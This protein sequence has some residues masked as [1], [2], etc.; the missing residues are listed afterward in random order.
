[1]AQAGSNDKKNWG[2]KISLDCPFK[3]FV[4]SELF[5]FNIIYEKIR[6]EKVYFYKSQVFKCLVNIG[7]LFVFWF[8]NKDD[9]NC[10]GE[11]M[12]GL[13]TLSIPSQRLPYLQRYSTHS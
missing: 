8:V 2:S 3:H 11:V 5:E 10:V 7:I 13:V 4:I 1:M 6:S 9:N 12:S